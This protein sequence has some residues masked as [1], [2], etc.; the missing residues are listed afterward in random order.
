MESSIRSAILSTGSFVPS[1]RV[2]S[3][4]L[5]ARM[6]IPE[7]WILQRTG[8]KSRQLVD[9]ETSSGDLGYEAAKIALERAGVPA[10]DLELI[11]V[12]TSTPDYPV[13]PSNGCLLQHRL[14][15]TRAAAFD[16]SAAC[17]GFTFG[18]HTADQFVRAG[19][20]KRVLLVCTD[21]LT[22][23][24]DWTDRST[25]I[26]FGDAAGAM[27]LGP[28]DSESGLLGSYIRCDG[29][30]GPQMLVPKG[31]SRMAPMTGEVTNGEHFIRM[32]GKAVFRFAVRAVVDAFNT[33]LT[34]FSISKSDIDVV[35]LHQANQRIIDQVVS[36]LGIAPEKV[37]GNIDTYG[38][39]SVASIPLVLDLQSSRLRK[40]DLVLAIG[41]GA[42]FTWG[43]N[44]IRW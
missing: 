23:Y 3:Q 21:T 27:L 16:L 39:T 36:T 32:N 10:S 20:Y 42:G 33:A 1:L 28:S 24:V 19:T 34:Q 14:G 40:G 12:A 35:V 37:L 30:G 29:S 18:L 31:G 4:E 7:D 22:K 43:A 41:F 17:S 25:S 26:L 6:D 2:T 44:L 11:I 8:I 5:A 9:R 13:F 15:A 38:N